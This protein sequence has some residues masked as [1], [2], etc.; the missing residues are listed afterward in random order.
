MFLFSEQDRSSLLR[1][2]D[3]SRSENGWKEPSESSRDTYSL[4]VKRGKVKN[5]KLCLGWRVKVVR[6]PCGLVAKYW[7]SPQLKFELKCHKH[8]LRFESIVRECNGE[9]FEALKIYCRELADAG[10]KRWNRIRIPPQY[11][12]L[13]EK[14]NPSKPWRGIPGNKNVGSGHDHLLPG[15]EWSYTCEV[16]DGM[17]QTYW[18]SPQ[19]LIK[20][21]LRLAAVE[22]EKIR[23]Q[24]DGDEN[25]AWSRFKEETKNRGAV[26]SDYVATP[27]RKLLQ[28]N[29]MRLTELSTNDDVCFICDDGG[30]E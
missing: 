10:V 3:G 27:D 16:C 28:S 2:R 25:K 5:K 4:Q 20:F 29:S 22:F 15:P 30:G 21:R 1:I 11:S 19:L 18:S 13:L 8:A 26:L 24:Y 6:F 12:R 7:I 9:E 14:S 23:L 17:T